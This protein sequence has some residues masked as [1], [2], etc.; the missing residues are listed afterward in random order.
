MRLSVL[1]LMLFAATPAL[2][3]EPRSE[4]AVIAADGSWLKAEVAGDGDF[5]DALLLPGYVS[6]GPDGKI[7]EKAK[8]VANARARNAEAKAKLAAQVAAWR[9]SHPIRAEV[10]MVGDTAILKWVLVKPEAGNPISS[11]DVFVYRDGRW[12]ALY[13]QHSSAAS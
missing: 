13:S 2:A 8:L 6:I 5:L 3:A 1:P 10:T 11:C 12:R 7:L 4:A 9:A